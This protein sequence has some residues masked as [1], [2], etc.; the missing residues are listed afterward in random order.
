MVGNVRLSG[1]PIEGVAS[2]RHYEFKSCGYLIWAQNKYP[3]GP[4]LELARCVWVLMAPNKCM[5]KILNV[6]RE[7][8][9]RCGLSG[10]S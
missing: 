2:R 10:C 5:L 8:L 7:Q 9:P 3:Q 1:D 4:R 6:V